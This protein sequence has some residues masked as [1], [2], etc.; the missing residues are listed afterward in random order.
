MGWHGIGT[1]VKQWQLGFVQ[2]DGQLHSEHLRR[3][4]VAGVQQNH[5]PDV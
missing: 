1:I 4:C 5:S 3:H 2:P